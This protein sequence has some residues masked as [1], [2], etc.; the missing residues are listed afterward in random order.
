M[1]DEAAL[2]ETSTA[3]R[4]GVKTLRQNAS[5]EYGQ[6]VKPVSGKLDRSKLLKATDDI[7][8]DQADARIT[9][10]G[11]DITNTPLNDVE[12]RQLQKIYNV[13]DTWDDFTPQGV[14][15]LATRISRFRRGSDDSQ[16]FDRIVDEV[17]RTV[18]TQVGDQYPE[19]AEANANFAARMD[20]ID[21]L[22][23]ILKTRGAVDS[24]QGIRETSQRVARL[25]NSNK[26]L[27][28]E[29]VESLEK[30]LGIDVLGV[31]AGRRLSDNA[32]LFQVGAQDSAMGLVR[33]AIPRSVIGNIVVQTG[34]S[35]QA[36]EAAL[37]GSLSGLEPTAQAA[38]VE[39]LVNLY[40]TE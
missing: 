1:A 24:Q 15:T 30:E 22:D 38:V 14:N 29:A 20:L 33:S 3:V 5:E 32:S 23:S 21:D 31:E 37:A 13:I 10:E 12:E 7:F 35:Q 8:V 25:F 26:E 39:T 36:V 40:G 34:K 18:R 17:R 9:K 28:R 27:S 6:L 16:N 19:I 11:L 4:S 2:K